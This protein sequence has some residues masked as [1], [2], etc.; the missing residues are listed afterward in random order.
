MPLRATLLAIAAIVLP[1]MTQA[2]P[3]HA[4]Q[5]STAQD[6][7]DRAVEAL[8]QAAGPGA[9]GLTPEHIQQAARGLAVVSRELSAQGIIFQAAEW[10][11]GRLPQIWD[12]VSQ[13]MNQAVDAM[14]SGS[15]ASFHLAMT[16][17]LLQIELSY[18]ILC[19]APRE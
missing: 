2:A 14:A 3:S 17:F 5:C 11:G 15:V 10:K 16:A 4:T 9:D 18:E 19:V 13:L 7:I 12:L 6:A 8:A 1:W